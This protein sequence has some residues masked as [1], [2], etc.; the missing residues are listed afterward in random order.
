MTINSS[1]FSPWNISTPARKENSETDLQVFQ[2]LNEALPLINDDT[3]KINLLVKLKDKGFTR[4][5]FDVTP[6]HLYLDER[7]SLT[8]E[9][10][11]ALS[12][13]L[14]KSKIQEKLDSIQKTILTSEF[15]SLKGHSHSSCKQFNTIS[16][17]GHHYIATSTPRSLFDFWKMVLE[18]RSRLVLQ[19]NNENY[20][21][22]SSVFS[23]QKDK[24]S[25]QVYSESTRHSCIKIRELYMRYNDQADF[26]FTHIHFS[27]WPDFGVPKEED[28]LAL[29]RTLDESKIQNKEDSPYV[30]HC[31]AGIG[32]T[33]TF[34]LTHST[35][36][37]ASPN[38]KETLL[39]MRAQRNPQMVETPAQYIFAH[40][41]H[42]KWR[43][44]TG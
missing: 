13:D 15:T 14:E 30:V 31:G 23:S 7:L 29:L 41:M 42:K 22:N 38:F 12:I 19:L 39:S 4:V 8:T 24:I 10:Q 28:M 3:T 36:E 43:T 32:R 17:H 1:S 16:L 25:V 11:K 26:H 37:E 35:L 33:G 18:N 6:S 34:M 44:A 2:I 27:A 9:L 40:K 20:L 21:S 5:A